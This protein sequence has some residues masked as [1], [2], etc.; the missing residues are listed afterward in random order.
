MS[1]GSSVPQQSCDGETAEYKPLYLC[2]DR[3]IPNPQLFF[4][5]LSSGCSFF[6]VSWRACQTHHDGPQTEGRLDPN[7]SLDQI[8]P[9]GDDI[10]YT[11]V[12]DAKYSRGEERQQYYRV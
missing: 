9:L 6:A 7:Q 8:P 11:C 1:K 4:L 10:V 5:I 2:M 12:M 3:L